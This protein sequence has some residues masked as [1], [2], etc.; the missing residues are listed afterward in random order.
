MNQERLKDIS[1]IGSNLKTFHLNTP[2]QKNLYNDKI[3]EFA[4]FPVTSSEDLAGI[5]FALDISPGGSKTVSVKLKQ[6]NGLR[7][8]KVK[9]KQKLGFMY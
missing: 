9:T 5:L 1:V 2:E 6:K 3:I 8:Y 4:G 7:E